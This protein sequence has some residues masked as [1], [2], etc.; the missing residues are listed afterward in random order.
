MRVLRQGFSGSLLV[1]LAN[2]LTWNSSLPA[3]GYNSWFAFD[4]HLNGESGHRAFS[5]GDHGTPAPMSSYAPSE[6]NMRS[7][8]DALVSTGLAAAGYIFCNMDGGWQGGRYSN[9]SV[10]ANASAFPSGLAALGDY[11]HAR[12]LLFGGYTD[13][14]PETCDGHTG[15]LNFEA[16][17]AAQ[18]AAWGMDYVKVRREAAAAGCGGKSH[19]ASLYAQEDSCFATQSHGA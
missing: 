7:N 13:R 3:R 11:M 14:G 8:A 10:Y 17:D 18:Y 6:T 5:L 15:S 9:H 2:A 4:V 16:P 12:G 1:V 19:P